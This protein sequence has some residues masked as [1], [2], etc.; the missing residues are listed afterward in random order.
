MVEVGKHVFSGERPAES[1]R[2]LSRGMRCPGCERLFAPTLLGEA[3]SICDNVGEYLDELEEILSPPAPET[4]TD[5]ERA[6]QAVRPSTVTCTAA[7]I[8]A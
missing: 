4:M 3:W 8:E 2:T 1:V 7:P 6:A 5:A